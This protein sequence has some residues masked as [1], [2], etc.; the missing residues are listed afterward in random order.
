VFASLFP[1][2]TGKVVVVLVVVFYLFLRP[3]A[4]VLLQLCLL[5]IEVACAT[6]CCDCVPLV[7]VYELLVLVAVCCWLRRP[8]VAGICVRE[9]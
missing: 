8:S 5:R 6:C 9:C 2:I 7:G 3:N 4:A 1:S